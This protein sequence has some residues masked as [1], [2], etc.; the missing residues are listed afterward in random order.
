MKDSCVSTEKIGEI[1]HPCTCNLIKKYQCSLKVKLQ[2]WYY[3]L[4]V[5]F[6]LSSRSKQPSPGVG[7]LNLTQCAQT[8]VKKCIL[9]VVF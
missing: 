5:I 7:K 1:A 4:A 6:S 3:V 2:L 9:N 8:Q